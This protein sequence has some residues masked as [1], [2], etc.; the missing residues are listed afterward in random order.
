MNI[1]FGDIGN[2]LTKICIVNNKKFKIKKTFYFKSS[3]I[4][5]PKLLQ[6]N[7]NKILE[8]KSLHKVALFSSVA[9]KYELIMK[10]FFQTFYKI[11]INEIKEIPFDNLIKINIKK[12]KQVGSDRVANAIGAFKQYK[13]NCIILDFGTATTYSA[14]SADRFFL[15]TT[16][17][18]GF[19]ISINALKTYA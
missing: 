4:L 14:I 12:K 13:T 6:K 7:L 1:I 19:K 15:G 8:N 5:S 11:K 2:T 17:C 9:P 16:I 18:P 3:E 10:K